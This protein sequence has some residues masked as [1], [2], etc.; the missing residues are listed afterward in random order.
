MGNDR[1]RADTQVLQ[2]A[3]LWPY[4]RIQE[5]RKMPGKESGSARAQ[6]E[7]STVQWS[8]LGYPGKT[9]WGPAHMR[10]LMS[11]KLEHRE[12]RIAFEELLEGIRQESERMECL[13]DAIREVVP[14][15]S[16]AEVVAALQAMR[17][18]DLI[19]AVGVLAEIGD[20]SRF[21]NPREL[22]GYLGLVPTENSTGDKVKRGGITKA[23]NGRARRIVVEAAWSYRYPPRVS[24]DKQPKVEAAPRRARDCVES[25]NQIV[26]TLPLTRAEGQAANRNR[27]GD[28]P[29]AIRLHLGNQSRAHA[30]STGV[31]SLGL[32]T[33]RV[34]RCVDRPTAPF[35]AIGIRGSRRHQSCRG[36]GGTAAGEILK[37]IMWPIIRSM[38]DARPGTA[39][40]E[41]TEMRYPTRASE[42]VHR[43]LWVP[44]SPLHDPSAQELHDGRR[45]DGKPCVVCL[46]VDIRMGW[47]GRAPAPPAISWPGAPRQGARHVPDTQYRDRRDRHRYR[48]K[49]VPRRGPR[50]ARHHRAAAKVVAW[51]GG[52]AA[53]QTAAL[54][55]RHGSLRRRTSFEPQ[56]RI[57]RSRCQVDAGQICPPL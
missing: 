21:Q 51:P 2:R 34:V 32:W 4:G 57:V 11:Q 13:E 12:Q 56:T 55:D 9:T 42:P 14:E 41:K 45:G 17:G 40:D 49:L 53:R 33:A 18:I 10:W 47:S 36:E 5:I 16:L 43:R 54:P 3:L 1:L 25:A 46:T 27:H 37:P 50:Y 52:G 7:I 30:I 28:C 15:W 20:L 23:G 8:R 35:V 24:R 29:R 39:P 38:P 26:R 48:Q 19:A 22:M 6:L 44:P 31:T